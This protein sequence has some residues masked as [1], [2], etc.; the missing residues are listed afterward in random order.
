MNLGPVQST[1]AYAAPGDLG[2]VADLTLDISELDTNG[3]GTVGD[4]EFAAYRSQKQAKAGK[5]GIY[6]DGWPCV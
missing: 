6:S 4:D 2:D 5:R 3:D 1:T